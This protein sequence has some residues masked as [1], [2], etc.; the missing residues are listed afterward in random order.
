MFKNMKINKRLILAFVVAV[1]VSS[2]AGIVGIV[3]LNLTDTSYSDALV[4]YGF[5]QGDVGNLG[6][7]FQKQRAATLYLLTNTDPASAT[8]YA[9]DLVDI[10]KTIAAD[11]LQVNKGLGSELGQQTYA[12]LTT[13]W[14][15]YRV[16][17][18]EVIAATA[19]SRGESAVLLLKEKCGVSSAAVSEIIDTMLSDKSRIGTEKSTQLTIQTQIFSWLMIA[20][21]IVAMILACALAIY[22][23]R[24]ISKPIAQVERAAKEMA[25]GNFEVQVDF[26]SRDE[27]GS[28]A[29]S[30]RQMIKTTKDIDRK[31]VV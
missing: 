4:T 13:A 22:T 18:D 10:D 6:R 21:M 27:I 31:S 29:E 9:A 20:V 24:G 5:A 14:D 17:R 2:V 25:K 15:T 16:E 23:A 30:M 8:T 19:S 26:T 3:L 7:H 1:L 11:L 28:L 12:K